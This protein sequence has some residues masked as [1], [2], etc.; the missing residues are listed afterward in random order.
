MDV[1]PPRGTFKHTQWM[2]KQIIDAALELEVPVRSMTREQFLRATLDVTRTDIDACESWSG[3]RRLA[4]AHYAAQVGHFGAAPPLTGEDV[5][6]D[7]V[8]EGYFLRHTST[9]VDDEGNV[10]EQSLK[11]SL[12]QAEG[13][14]TDII[15]KGQHVKGV[16]SLV[17]GDGRLVQ[18]WIKTAKDPETKQEMLARL[19]EEL[20]KRVKARKGQIKLPDETKLDKDLLAVYPLGDRHIG[21]LSWAPETG[22]DFDL[23]KAQ[24]I[25]QAAMVDL[26][27]PTPHAEQALIINLGDFFHTDNADNKTARSGHA[28]DVDGRWPKV[29]QV[30]MNIMIFLVDTALSVHSRVRVINEIGNHD[31]HSAIFLSIALNAYYANEPRVE[32]DMSP[33]NFHWYRCGSNLIGVTHGHNVKAG[34]LES[35]MASE[36]KVDWGETDHRF[37]YCGHIHHSTKKE[38]RGC[39]IETFRTLSA[40][41]AWAANAGYR[42]G[43]DMNRIVLHREWGEQYRSTVNASYL[44]QKY[45]LKHKI[46]K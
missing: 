28:L 27:A 5:P 30:G 35:I 16:S 11:A 22:E 4:S 34:E 8:P 20:P 40:R 6:L 25:M 26:V 44:A 37:W 31:D 17:S 3:I 2:I 39:V 23:E 24:E 36:R 33:S 45:Q 43:R 12:L 13:E 7:A 42:S 1:K 38:T 15:P 32:I 18:Q 46:K 10:I 14:L 29:L 19:L 9:R 21:M 41:D